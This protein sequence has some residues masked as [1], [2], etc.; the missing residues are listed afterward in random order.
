MG[1]DFHWMSPVSFCHGVLTL[2]R[3]PKLATKMIQS[4]WSH[5]T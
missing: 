3:K 5:E 4:V 2:D 1:P